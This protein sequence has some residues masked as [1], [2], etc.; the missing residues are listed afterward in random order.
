M[1]ALTFAAPGDRELFGP[2]LDLLP[3]LDQQ[4]AALDRVK[5]TGDV[6]EYVIAWLAI[7]D[8]NGGGTC[9]NWWNDDAP[10]AD[11]DMRSFVACDSQEAER[12][13]RWEALHAYHETVDGFRPAMQR[14]LLRRGRFVDNRRASLKEVKAVV[15]AFIATGG[16]LLMPPISVPTAPNRPIEASFNTRAFLRGEWSDAEMCAANAMVRLLRR[17]RARPKIERILRT[18]GNSQN[19]WIVLGDT[20]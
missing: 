16:R 6:E 18:L 2:D 1:T 7:S 4:I 8:E 10:D 13:A 12:R 19:G 3:S 17:W 5:S 11:A 9:A 15:R 14:E 20:K